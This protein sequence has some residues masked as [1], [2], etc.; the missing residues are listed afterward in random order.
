MKKDCTTPFGQRKK[1]NKKKQSLQMLEK[2]L[3][4]PQLARRS[5]I[6]KRA[7]SRLYKKKLRRSLIQRGLKLSL[8][9][10]LLNSTYRRKVHFINIMGKLS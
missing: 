8:S 6:Y 5:A 10:A 7:I 2:F 9:K 3:F 4:Q 1:R